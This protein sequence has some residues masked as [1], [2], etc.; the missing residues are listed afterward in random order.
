MNF[1][2]HILHGIVIKNETYLRKTER[3]EK[4]KK[5]KAEETTFAGCK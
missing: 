2:I 5:V 4:K 3:F 1:Q